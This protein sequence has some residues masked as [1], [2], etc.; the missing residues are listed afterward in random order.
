[1]TRRPGLL[2]RYALPLVLLAAI[3][4]V[5]VRW[6]IPALEDLK[7]MRREAAVLESE[8]VSREEAAQAARDLRVGTTDDALLRERLEIEASLSP[9]VR[10]PII[11]AD[12]EEPVDPD[13]FD[14]SDGR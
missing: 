3:A 11:D 13:G 1:M 8:R 12:P 7:A 9:D 14:P 10:G 2:R 5:F 4:W 6:T